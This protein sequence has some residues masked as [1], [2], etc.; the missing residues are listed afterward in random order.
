VAALVD[1]EQWKAILRA[2]AR[3]HDY[4]IGNI[5]LILAQRPDA[6]RV[7]GYRTWQAL[8]RQVTRGERDPTIDSWC[9]VGPPS[10]T[11]P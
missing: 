6:T 3:F 1:G 8:G 11:R 10:V 7:A 4:S 2:A 5:L 9:R